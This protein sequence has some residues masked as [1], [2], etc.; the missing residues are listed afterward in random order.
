M[1]QMRDNSD[2][3]IWLSDTITDRFN[4]YTTVVTIFRLLHFLTAGDY[5][6]IKKSGKTLIFKMLRLDN[7]EQSIL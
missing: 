1:Q 2:L 5:T 4:N 6:E 7:F 3:A